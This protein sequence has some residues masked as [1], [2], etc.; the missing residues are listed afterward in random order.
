MRGLG[1]ARDRRHGRE[2][3]VAVGRRD[4]PAH[5]LKGLGFEGLGFGFSGVGCR[6]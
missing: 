1:G 3:E 4:A 2:V 6:A 5:L